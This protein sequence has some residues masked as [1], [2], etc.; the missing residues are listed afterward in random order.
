MIG[1]GSVPKIVGFGDNVVDCYAGR[2]QMFPGGN[3]LNVAVQARR[4]GASSA[5]IGA[6]ADDP[7]GRHIR[8]ALIAEDVDIARLR[9]LPGRTAFCVIG[10]KDGEREF[11]RADLGVSIIEPDAG[12]LDAIAAADAVHTGRSSHVDAHLADFAARTRLSFDFAVIR[13]EARIAAIAPHCFLASFSGAD[14]PEPEAETLMTNTLAAGAAWC[15]V[16]RGDA[17]AMLAGRDGVHR[18]PP[19]PAELIDTLGAGDA[20]IARCLVGLLRGEDPQALLPAAAR[21]A[22]DTCGHAGGFGHPAP[23]QIDETH[24]RT[25]DEIYRGDGKIRA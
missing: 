17:G 24:A 1:E 19:A 25:L 15:L 2:D 8:A 18:T 21:Q 4:S 11:L 5:Y 10:T 23:M 12:D 20:F 16:T 3:A 22:A 6:V 9:I 14:L 13:D 7:A